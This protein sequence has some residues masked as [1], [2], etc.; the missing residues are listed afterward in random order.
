MSPFWPVPLIVPPR[1]HTITAAIAGAGPGRRLAQFLRRV[2]RKHHFASFRDM[3]HILNA[4]A[5]FALV[6]LITG[7]LPLLSPHRRAVAA[8]LHRA[9]PQAKVK[10]AVF[11]LL[12]GGKAEQL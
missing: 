9:T 11:S 4:G 3:S 2:T 7:I 12:Q 5:A 10:A 1:C 6:A 8:D